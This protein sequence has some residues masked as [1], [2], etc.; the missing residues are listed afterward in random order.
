MRRVGTRRYLV[1]ANG[2]ANAAAVLDIGDEPAEL[3]RELTELID[4]ELGHAPTGGTNV[5][6]RLRE[7][8][9]SVFGILLPDQISACLGS[10]RAQ[11]GP[12]C[13]RLRFDLPSELQDLPVEALCSPAERAEQT[14]ALNATLSV[15]RSLPG[16]PS[17]HRLPVAADEPEHIELLVAVASPPGLP[18]LEYER[19][20]AEL[21]RA[22]PELAVRRT[23]LR[24][25]TRREV[26]SWLTEH[27]DQPA[28]VLLI[29]HGRFDEA[30]GEGVVLLESED[31]GGT[32][33]MNG[34]LLSGILVQARRLRLVVLNLCSGAHSA[35]VE[36]FSGVAQAL[37]GRGIPAVAAMSGVVT[38]RAAGTFGPRLLE[39]IC[40]NRTVDESMTAARQHIAS[41]PGHTSIEWAT[42]VLFL[43]REHGHGWLFK[44]RE[45]H[46]DGDEVA[47]PLRAGEAALDRLT[48]PGNVNMTSVLS[49][50]TFLRSRYDW[51]GVLRT[52]R[53]GKRTPEQ[54]RLITEARIELAWPRIEQLCAVLAE[55]DDP[56]RAR[57]LLDEVRKL[58]PAS[59]FDQL[60][61]EVDRA[62]GLAALADD[63]RRADAAGDW[64]SAL[65]N[66]QR[67]LDERPAGFGD[68]DARLTA[69]KQHAERAGQEAE[70]A[71][72]WEKAVACYGVLPIEQVAGR[73]EYA[74]GRVAE[75]A[76]D[77]ALAVE[78]FEGCEHADALVRLD[79]ARGRLAEQDGEW[80][81]ACGHYEQL[82]RQL[83]DTGSRIQY[84]AGRSADVR[85]DWAEVI[86]GFGELP[87]GF[88]DGEV[89]RRR[90]FARARIA[91]LHEDWRS[92]LALLGDAPDAERDGRVG[93]A[94]REA[95][96]RL[97]EAAEDWASAVAAYAPVADADPELA[98]AHRYAG[99][100]MSEQDGDWSGALARYGDLPGDYRDL[101]HRTSYA[102]ARLTEQ[103]SADWARLVAAYAAL[104][105]DFEDARTRS[106]Y[107]RLRSAISRQEWENCLA[108]AEALGDH[109]DT[110][111][112]IS[113]A[114]GRLAE[115]RDDWSGAV[116]A[117]D[118]C[119]EHADSADRRAYANGRDLERGGHWS[120]AIAA[121]EQ[122]D[123]PV[124]D[125]DRRRD[126]LER[127][128]AALP[129]ADGLANAALVADPVAWREETFPYR[130]LRSA[131]VTPASPTE[132][133]KDAIYTLMERG[134]ISW[135]ERVAWDQLHTPAKRL[136]L[137]ARL[138]RF[139]DPAAVGRELD[140]LQPGDAPALLARLCARLPED[141]P[142]LKLL[143][144]N[145][146]EALAAWWAQLAEAP[147][148]TAVVHRIAVASFWQAEELEET[149]AWEQAE[150]VWRTAL[151]CWAVVLT[152]D[153]YWIA[154]RQA[155]AACYGH[156]VTP[157]DSARLRA[158]LGRYLNDLLT[159]HEERH[160]SAGRPQ[161]AECYRNLVSFL[162]AELGAA[163]ALKEAGGLPLPTGTLACGPAYV[164]M[165]GLAGELGKFAANADPAQVDGAES[166]GVVL[167][168]LRWSFSELS[169]A[170][171]LIEHHRFEA[172]LRALPEFHRQ[173]LTELPADCGGPES[174]AEPADCPRCQDFL[175]RNPAHAMLPN[176]R[177]RLLQDAVE[178]AVWAHLSLARDLLAGRDQ[179]AAAIAELG[180]A[181]EVSANAAMT[182]RT[183]EAVLRMVLGRVESL[184]SFRRID[185]LD[186]AIALVREAR[187]VVGPRGRQTLTRKW[188]DMLVDAGVWYGSACREQG[189]EPDIRRAVEVLREALQLN[190]ES[191]LVR[192][193]LARALV[194]GRTGLPGGRTAAGGFAILREAYVIVHEGLAPVLPNS[195]LLESLGDVLAE[196]ESSLLAKLDLDELGGLVRTYGDEAGAALDAPG[197]ARA[198]AEEAERR[199]AGNDPVGSVH[200]LVRATRFDPGNAAVR[201]AL[202]T[203]LDEELAR[204]RQDGSDHR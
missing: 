44:A 88:A 143:A 73:K 182:V 46:E 45:V 148:E 26:E 83:L 106:D 37:I 146:A 184:V 12:P 120:A 170:F 114:R 6:A 157:A 134:G 64:A 74:E 86:A 195:W 111:T 173:R 199:R 150:Q 16:D 19:E 128:L 35:R 95:R 107:A 38:D 33:H 153:E 60:R 187:A 133:V 53:T 115:Q 93:V 41:L 65:R 75:A 71:Q 108:M 40:S 29:A 7:L 54:D 191:P 28:A 136:L 147:G 4:I 90:R 189:I 18:P 116:S 11:P 97:A 47:D 43:H 123:R 110:A 174:H 66:Y 42:P 126:R 163:Q 154:W 188:A 23:V 186:E 200:A 76:E 21:E 183:R 2:P 99:G 167:R 179:G 164:R 122:L 165:L 61:D 8:G 149:G 132:I 176:R 5:V 198:L 155:R 24:H 125:S 87:D 82:P 25:A 102:R 52:L 14:L 104:P 84:A 34:Q 190:P 175:E 138:Y 178:L 50:A 140:D 145:R 57:E 142:L 70:E 127:L 77:W 58:L 51:D 159:R 39:G 203:A 117:Y 55:E 166:E 9:R 22:L 202:L 78:R 96:G 161:Q 101:R 112:L 144:G 59:L 100:R 103:E 62:A 98:R 81:A 185:R 72:D 169:A 197:R 13:L 194:Y 113:Y 119:A 105:D 91:A 17:A 109:R 201:A 69:A 89:G 30:M 121:F 177:F 15:T 49:A 32:D 63:A 3:R 180:A 129:W 79:Y 85:E 139:R 151:S 118:A 137:D 92:A 162:E 31:G 171:A 56:G 196:L 1:L 156:A 94:R 172:A 204:R 68:V 135:Q 160:T 20:L 27:S 192:G 168:R 130:A 36:P 80:D 158:E 124:L 131:G 193:H 10:A 48:A 181:I 67:V 141:A 152:D